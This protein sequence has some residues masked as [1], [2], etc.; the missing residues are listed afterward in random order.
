MCIFLETSHIY[1]NV[2][3]LLIVVSKILRIAVFY[4]LYCNKTKNDND[5]DDVYV[6]L[7]MSGTSMVVI[8]I[9]RGKYKKHILSLVCLVTSI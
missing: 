8:I 2:C 9:I 4:R 5:D 1:T 6:C 7:Y 3:T